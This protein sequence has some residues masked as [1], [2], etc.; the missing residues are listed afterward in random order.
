MG[1]QQ[2]SIVMTVPGLDPEIVPVIHAAK[3]PRLLGKTLAKRGYSVAK[4]RLDGVDGQDKDGGV[5]SCD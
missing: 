1:V 4:R 3:L 5:R 2:L